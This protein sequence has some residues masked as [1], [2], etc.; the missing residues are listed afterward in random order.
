MNIEP[1][2]DTAFYREVSEI[3]EEDTT[4]VLF[5]T[6]ACESCQKAEQRKS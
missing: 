3:G 4:L 6:G 2:K 1:E 5:V